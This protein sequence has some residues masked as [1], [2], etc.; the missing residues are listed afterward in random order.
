MSCT[1]ALVAG[2]AWSGLVVA[3]TRR[4]M[5]AGEGGANLDVADHADEGTD[6][7]VLVAVGRRGLEHAGTRTHHQ[8]LR[9]EELLALVLRDVLVQWRLSGE[10]IDQLVE[11]FRRRDGH[12]GH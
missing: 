1:A 4:P 2:T 11:I 12:A 5:S 7:D 6:F 10:R 3:R 9:H 8:P